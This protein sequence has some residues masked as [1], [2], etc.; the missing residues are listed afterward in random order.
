MNKGPTKLQRRASQHIDVG[1]LQQKA[2]QEFEAIC[3]EDEG[4]EKPKN[5]RE[6]RDH[7]YSMLDAGMLG[8]FP[9]RENDFGVVGLLAELLADKYIEIYEM[10]KSGYHIPE[11]RYEILTTSTVDDGYHWRIYDHKEQ[12]RAKV[13]DFGRET[14]EEAYADT[15]EY[16]NRYLK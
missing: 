12:K 13:S 8:N 10:D 3:D 11:N 5:W 7:F 15:E 14:R 4:V 9:D 6:A 2:R 1:M 16:F